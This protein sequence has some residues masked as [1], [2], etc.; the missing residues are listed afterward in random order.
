MSLRELARFVGVDHSTLWQIEHD[1]IENPKPAIQVRV[2]KA[3]RVPLDR[4][5][6]Q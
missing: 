5:F 4:V 2:A 1:R 6:P 3:L